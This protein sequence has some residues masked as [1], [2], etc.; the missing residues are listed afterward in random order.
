MAS[1]NRSRN[2]K[3]W[4]V[5]AGLA[6]VG[7]AIAIGVARRAPSGAGPDDGRGPSTSAPR[8]PGPARTDYPANAGASGGDA[9]PS[10]DPPGEKQIENLMGTWRNAILNKEA[11]AVVAADGSFL[12]EPQKFL[13]PLMTSAETDTDDRVR[14]FSTRM[15]GKMKDPACAPVFQRLLA[16]KSQYVRMH[17]AC[18]LGEL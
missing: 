9:R 8:S 6:L 1:P 10:G 17:A 15:L 14:A 4:V 18:G 5:F 11:D 3:R 7:L 12:H 16:D 13:Q 2:Q